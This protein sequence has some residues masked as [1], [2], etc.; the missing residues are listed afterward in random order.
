MWADDVP[1][2]PFL[3]WQQMG[4]L[5]SQYHED[6]AQLMATLCSERDRQRA[7]CQVRIVGFMESSQNP[8]KAFE[9]TSQQRIAEKALQLMR[10]KVSETNALLEARRGSMRFQLTEIENHFR[11]VI[12]VHERV[13]KFAHNLQEHHTHPRTTLPAEPQHESILGR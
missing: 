13:W 10:A 6:S 3:T 9:N 5:W 8:V 12:G 2:S 11:G 4:E 1:L 7:V